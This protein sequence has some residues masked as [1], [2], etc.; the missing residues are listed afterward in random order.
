MIE[1]F[2]GIKKIDVAEKSPKMEEI[3]RFLRK[4]FYSI[5]ATTA[6]FST[7]EKANAQTTYFVPQETQMIAER[8]DSGLVQLSKITDEEISYMSNFTGD[9]A[10]EYESGRLARFGALFEL[11]QRITEITHDASFELSTVENILAAS[12]VSIE[13]G[14]HD[15]QKRLP[16]IEKDS[17]TEKPGDSIFQTLTFQN[18]E[19]TLMEFVELGNDFLSEEKNDSELDIKRLERAVTIHKEILDLLNALYKKCFLTQQP[20]IKKGSSLHYQQQLGELVNLSK[21]IDQVI[22]SE[23]NIYN[24]IIYTVDTKKASEIMEKV[25]PQAQTQLTAESLDQAQKGLI[26]SRD[27]LVSFIQ[28]GGWSKQLVTEQDTYKEAQE[29][30]RNY[31]NILSG[32]KT[33]D[34]AKADSVANARFLTSDTVTIQFNPTPSK[35]EAAGTTSD[36]QWNL[37]KNTIAYNPFLPLLG[38]KFATIQTHEQQHCFVQRMLTPEELALAA[39]VPPVG[40]ITESDSIYFSE[41]DELFAF[42]RQTKSRMLELGYIEKNQVEVDVDEISE[43][44]IQDWDLIDLSIKK[45]FTIYCNSFSAGDNHYLMVENLRSFLR[46]VMI[47]PD[48]IVSKN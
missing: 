19:M 18:K 35:Y 2:P 30:A 15:I 17:E 36:K 41:P 3:E 37:L 24:K 28:D 46:V 47:T 39:Q 14:A 44:F 42:A 1:Q 11:Q 12:A 45:A 10:A 43:K 22:L 5:V 33:M 23:M 27:R 9:R 8:V 6:F 26:R 38:H 25:A 13:N 32:T 40:A 34:P 21:K 16:F 20:F 31:S 4:T 48:E 7:T 29:K